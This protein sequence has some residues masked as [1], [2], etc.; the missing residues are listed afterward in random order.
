MAV[1]ERVVTGVAP[2]AL[3]V[4]MSLSPRPVGLQFANFNTCVDYACSWHVDVSLDDPLTDTRT[5][6][7]FSDPSY[8]R[9]G[10]AL[11]ESNLLATCLWSYPRDRGWTLFVIQL[12]RDD[13][14]RSWTSRIVTPNVVVRHD[15]LYRSPSLAP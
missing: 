9:L 14:H 7:I 11:A 5:A 2:L 13:E 1:A 3:L 8:R 4:A 10:M 6:P 12:V 15:E